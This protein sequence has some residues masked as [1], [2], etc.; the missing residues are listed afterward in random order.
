M[1]H[2]DPAFFFNVCFVLFVSAVD[3]W[4]GQGS[5]TGKTTVGKVLVPK[6]SCREVN[7]GVGL[8]WWRLQ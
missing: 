2:A 3:Q 7:R 5:G 4:S 8:V 6:A 1:C